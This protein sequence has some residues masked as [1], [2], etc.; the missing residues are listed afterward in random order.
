MEVLDGIWRIV[1]GVS[2]VPTFG[3]L[4]QRLTLP[5]ATRYKKSEQQ[6]RR[7]ADEVHTCTT[8]I[9]PPELFPTGFK[10]FAHGMSA[11]CVK[12]RGR[13]LRFGVQHPVKESWHPA[14]FRI[15]FRYRFAGAGLI[16][17]LPEVK[18]RDVDL[19]YQEAE[20][21]KCSL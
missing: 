9:Y 7:F 3:T 12:A 14:V 20:K 15:F 1:I 2:L 11:A 13:Y 5:E 21:E 6:A 8:Y 10:A 16:L 17:L 19:M 18:T 4:C